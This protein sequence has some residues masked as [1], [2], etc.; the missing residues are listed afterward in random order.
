MIPILQEPFLIK[1]WAIKKDEIKSTYKFLQEWI[2]KYTDQGKLKRA[3]ITY[4]NLKDLKATG[5]LDACKKIKNLE[6]IISEPEPSDYKEYKPI[7]VTQ[8]E[9]IPNAIIFDYKEHPL[10]LINIIADGTL[11]IFE[12][13]QRFVFIEQAHREGDQ[14]SVWFINPSFIFALYEIRARKYKKNSKLLE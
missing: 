7:Y 4:K 9:I 12:E 2:N 10:S 8:E 11:R 6:I 13:G 3:I 1:E 5:V 14:Y